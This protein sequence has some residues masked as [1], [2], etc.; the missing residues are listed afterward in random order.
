MGTSQG[1]LCFKPCCIEGGLAEGSAGL[2]TNGGSVVNYEGTEAMA[3]QLLCAANVR[4]WC[5][6]RVVGEKFSSR[7]LGWQLCSIAGC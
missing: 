7:I 6:L 1:W 2:P 5:S 3:A 4:H